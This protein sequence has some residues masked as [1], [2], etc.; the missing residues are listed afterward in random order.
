MKKTVLIIGLVMMTQAGYSQVTV[1]PEI[2]INFAH[3]RSEI[4]SSNAVNSDAA[5]NFKAGIGVHIPLLV[6]PGMSSIY[7]KPGVSYQQQGGEVKA[8][9][10]KT[11]TNL[12]YLKM[13]VNLGFHLKVGDYA[14]AVFAEAGP[15]AGL[16][17]D[18][19]TKTTG[20]PAG[21]IKN[22]ISF[23]SKTSET[24]RFDWGFNFDIGY[25]TPFGIYVKGGYDLGLGNLSNVSNETINNRNWN[26]GLGYRFK[27]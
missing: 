25:E 8:G 22:D 9:A 20:G 12:H 14:G 15:Y 10:L 3:Q 1:D 13:P 17:L 6:S 24:N 4:G 16:A 26:I 27:L 21:E 2:G 5:V 23:G 19:N 7:L 11:K 18:G